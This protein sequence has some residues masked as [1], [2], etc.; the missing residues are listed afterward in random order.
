MLRQLHDAGVLGFHVDQ[1][2]GGWK[3]ALLVVEKILDAGG[4][5]TRIAAAIFVLKL[6]EGSPTLVFVVLEVSD[7]CGSAAVTDE[8]EIRIH[9]SLCLFPIIFL[10]LRYGRPVVEVVGP[11]LRIEVRFHM[12]LPGR[13]CAWLATKSFCLYLRTSHAYCQDDL[14]LEAW[15]HNLLR[16]AS[17]PGGM[18]SR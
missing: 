18:R 17:R 16:C 4:Q 3:V 2:L 11:I 9:L 8:Y 5:L 7:H 10:V 1:V 6:L 12:G 13:K 14:Y 15:A